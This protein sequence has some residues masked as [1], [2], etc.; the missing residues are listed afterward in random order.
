MKNIPALIPKGYTIG[1]DGQVVHDWVLIPKKTTPNS[2]HTWNMN[3]IIKEED[4][5]WN[6]DWYWG[7]N[8]IS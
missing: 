6:D 3:G 2:I 8:E 4:L 7:E 5:F 1:G